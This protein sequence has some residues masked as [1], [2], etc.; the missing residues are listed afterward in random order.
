M[1]WYL[2][3]I[4]GAHLKIIKDGVLFLVNFQNYQSVG[5]GYHFRFCSKKKWKPIFFRTFL[6]LKYNIKNKIAFNR[7]IAREVHSVLH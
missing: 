7:Y 1:P 6:Y 4:L 2:V 3:K 5:L